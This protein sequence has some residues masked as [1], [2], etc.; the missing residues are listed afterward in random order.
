MLFEL[1]QLQ[2]NLATHLHIPFFMMSGSE[3]EDELAIEPPLGLI[4][5]LRCCTRALKRQVMLPDSPLP[6]VL[7]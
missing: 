3:D 5:G 2:I 6:A 1:I 4:P 7:D